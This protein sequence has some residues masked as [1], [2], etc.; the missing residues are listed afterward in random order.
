[1]VTEPIPFDVAGDP[2]LAE[3]AEE[4]QRTRQPRALK[5]DGETL[6]YL[7]PA[8]PVRGKQSP[9]AGPRKPRRRSKRFTMDDPLWDIVGIA[10]SGGP[11]DVSEDRQDKPAGTSG[12][13]SRAKGNFLTGLLEIADSG[14]VP[15]GGPTDVSSNKH[16]YLA[17]AY[18]GKA[19]STSQE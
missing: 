4:V 17:D 9:E 19:D 14:A 13:R 1:V 11:G 2:Q 7:S 6:A 8:P 18:G 5:R 16:K 12:R 15:V 3:L 10:A